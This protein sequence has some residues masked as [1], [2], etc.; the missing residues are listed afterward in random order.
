[1]YTAV[2]S[3]QHTGDLKKFDFCTGGFNYI[4]F[5]SKYRHHL[6]QYIFGVLGNLC[7]TKHFTNPPMHTNS[8]MT[9]SFINIYLNLNLQLF[10]ISIN[11]IHYHSLVCSKSQRKYPV[12]K[13]LNANYSPANG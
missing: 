4:I 8:Y 2:L 7:K 12:L 11:I 3:F 5:C 13:L 9:G 1:M 10:F 6:H